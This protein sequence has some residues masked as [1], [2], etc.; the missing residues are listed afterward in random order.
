MIGNKHFTTFLIAILIMT[1]PG[2]AYGEMEN[3]SG[4]GSII[5]FW[6]LLD[7]RESPQEKFSN[8]S[9]LGPLFKLQW[10][11]DD[12]DIAVRPFFYSTFNKKDKATVTRVSLPAG[13]FGKFPGGFH[14]S[15]DTALPA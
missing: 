8:L 2:W 13:I 14:F 6:P 11:K 1:L 4:E 3:C 12:R 5:T 10:Q 7:Y 15:G 9:L